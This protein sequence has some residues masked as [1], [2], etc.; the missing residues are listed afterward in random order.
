MRCQA[1]NA[2]GSNSDGGSPLSLD[3]CNPGIALAVPPALGLVFALCASSAYRF[4][5]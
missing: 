2:I 5:V 4:S 3:C 1:V